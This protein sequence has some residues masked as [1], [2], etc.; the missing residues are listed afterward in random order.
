MRREALRSTVSYFRFQQLPWFALLA[1]LTSAC[2]RRHVAAHIPQPSRPQTTNT[3]TPSASATVSSAGNF[4]GSDSAASNQSK[5]P[6]QSASGTEVGYASWYGD[7]YHGRPAADGEIYDKNLMTAAHRTLP[8]NTM[9]KVTNL[10]NDLTATV[11]ITDRGPFVNGRIIDLSLAAAKQIQMVGPGTALVRLE[12][13]AQAL[14]AARPERYAVQVG[15]LT[16]QAAAAL[17]MHDMALR[18]GGAFIENYQTDTG[19]V[20]RVRVG[21]RF[22]E[23]GAQQLKQQLE[24]DSIPGFV[25]REDN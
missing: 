24:S 9:V 15:A 1:V 10:D 16:D 19:L 7:P 21:P 17:L 4:P 3:N 14:Q 18:Y 5:L 22:S 13:L 2:G 8:F 11:R 20:Y 23:S 12:V 25:V 6:A